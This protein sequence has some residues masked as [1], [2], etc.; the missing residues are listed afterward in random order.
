M[1][2]N[3]NFNITT[4]QC[5][6]SELTRYQIQKNLQNQISELP[7]YSEMNVD[8]CRTDDKQWRFAVAVRYQYH[9]LNVVHTG[10]SQKEVIAQGL[11]EFEKLCNIHKA[12]SAA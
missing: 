6:I 12:R 5:E 7:F 3:P 9:Q 10:V 8:I 4:T 11:S 2:I 1:N